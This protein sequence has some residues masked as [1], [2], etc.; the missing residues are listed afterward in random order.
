M[1][2]FLPLLVIIVLVGGVAAYF[3]NK[4]ESEGELSSKDLPPTL[5]RAFASFSEDDKLTYWS[6]YKR[7]KRSAVSMEILAILFPIQLFFLDKI[8]LAL[9]FWFTGGGCGVWYVVEWFLTP[10]RVREFNEEV[11]LQIARD[12]KFFA[13]EQ[14]TENPPP[15]GT[16]PES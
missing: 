5:Q 3:V 1:E 11:G 9:A 15:K 12:L 13:P 6:Q 14:G 2:D 16:D 8:G 4:K 7:K 10:K